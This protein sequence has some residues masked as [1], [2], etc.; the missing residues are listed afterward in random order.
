MHAE[1]RYLALIQGIKRFMKSA[2][3]DKVATKNTK[4]IV[5]C[6]DHSGKIK[7]IT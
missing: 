1:W 7:T 3:A 6:W 5:E 4:S 2:T